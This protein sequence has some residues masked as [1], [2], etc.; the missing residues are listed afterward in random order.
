M[1]LLISLLFTCGYAGGGPV[2]KAD[3]PLSKSP[4]GFNSAS[5]TYYKGVLRFGNSV[6]E[7]DD[8]MHEV[9]KFVTFDPV[10]T[11]WP[12][13]TVMAEVSKKEYHFHIPYYTIKNS[14]GETLNWVLTKPSVTIYFKNGETLTKRFW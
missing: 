4:D 9:E 8:Y 2:N 1:Y 13:V 14:D 5:G 3:D 11:T 10:A 7:A 6:A 12:G